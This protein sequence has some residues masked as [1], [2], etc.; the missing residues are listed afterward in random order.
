VTSV[1]RGVFKLKRW[2]QRELKTKI[3]HWVVK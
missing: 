2:T 1:T 3:F